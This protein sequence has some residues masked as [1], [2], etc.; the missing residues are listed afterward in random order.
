M[1]EEKL[2]HV[3]LDDV[4]NI[5]K[6]DVFWQERPTIRW[7][8]QG[9]R[10]SRFFHRMTKIKNKTKLISSIRNDDM[11]MFRIILKILADRIA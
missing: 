1:K 5:H 11:I 6:Q 8:I 7:H 4:D 3:K 10:N 9:D 2:A